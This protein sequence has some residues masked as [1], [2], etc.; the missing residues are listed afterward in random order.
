MISLSAAGTGRA[1][2]GPESVVEFAAKPIDVFDAIDQVF[3]VLPHSCEG[4]VADGARF[5]PGTLRGHVYFDHRALPERHIL[6][7]PED[8]IFVS[9]G[10][11]HTVLLV[12]SQR[13][14]PV[15]WCRFPRGRLRL[16]WQFRGP[17]ANTAKLT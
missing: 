8:A 7:R 6:K 11:G 9:C 13:C 2:R 3:P 14:T 16:W 1:P 15:R 4:Q 17:G 10:Y 5:G 12:Y